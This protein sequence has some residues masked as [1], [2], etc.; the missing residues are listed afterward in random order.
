MIDPVTLKSS[1]RLRVAPRAPPLSLKMQGWGCGIQL[2]EILLVLWRSQPRP[3]LYLP[4]LVEKCC[5]HELQ[6]IYKELRHESLSLMC[7]VS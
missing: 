2:P 1:F 3:Q 7:R 6:A 5:F 4:E